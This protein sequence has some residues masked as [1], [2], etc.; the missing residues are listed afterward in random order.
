MYQ[1]IIISSRLFFN[2][3]CLSF[4]PEVLFSVGNG[5]GYKRLVPLN[6]L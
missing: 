3:S 2:L 6:V 5:F 4:L 1:T